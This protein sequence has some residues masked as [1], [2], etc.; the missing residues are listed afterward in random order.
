M[1][2]KNEFTEGEYRMRTQ[3]NI[4]TDGGLLKKKSAALAILLAFSLFKMA[5]TESDIW[6]FT[7]ETGIIYVDADAVDGTNEGSSW[8][9]AFI[10]LQDALAV[11]QSGVEI[12]V[13]EGIY[14]PDQYVLMRPTGAEVVS[15]W[16][17]AASFQLINAVTL[18]GG[19]AGLGEPNPNAQDAITYETIL[20]GDLDGND[21]DVTNPQDLW[22]DPCRGQNSIHVVVA[23][24]TDETTVLDGFTITGGN[25][26]QGAGMYNDNSSPTVTNCV[27]RGNSAN[28]DGAGMYNE[29]SNPILTNCAFSEN[30][31]GL[32]GAGMY[33]DSSNPILISC[34]FSKNAVSLSGGG[35]CNWNCNPILMNCTFSGNS[36]NEGGGMANDYESSPALTNCT[37]RGNYAYY[38]GAGMYNKGNC[39]P[40]LSN[41]IFWNDGEEIKN[42]GEP[43]M[44][45]TYSNVRDGW[46]GEGN[47][48]AEPIFADA[49]YWADVNDQAV[50]I[51]PN[52]P[53]AVW[54]DGDYHLKSQAGRWDPVAEGW[55]TD[56]VTSPCI[57]AG[58]PKSPIGDEPSPNGS[59]INM[60]AYGA[61]TEASMS[62]P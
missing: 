14:K 11:A 41:C 46:P 1:H 40:V 19:F 34:A 39:S 4:K 52:S 30:F 56:D 60:G 33:N 54:I 25:S 38:G 18:K 59:R 5:K 23:S 27:F 8:D 17:R 58:D 12:R 37:F 16:D 6:S 21:K 31:A 44:T 50:V 9:N 48:D 13:A 47:I 57:D 45:I 15:T 28:W 43:T 32:D 2:T 53:M 62:L 42:D 3:Q 51:E 26:V 10:C 22:N 55:L 49:G 36:A 7:A 61:T 29:N 20:S 35:I 24:G